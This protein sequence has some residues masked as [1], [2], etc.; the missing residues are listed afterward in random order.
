[1]N[2]TQRRTVDKGN[3]GEAYVILKLIRDFNIVAVKVPQQFFSYDLI[4]SSN[5]RLEVKTAI[6]RNFPRTHAKY[7]TYNSYGWEFQ[8]NPPQLQEDASNYVVG[9]CKKTEN[10]SEDPRCFIIPTSDLREH[11]S[12]F[13]ILA[14]PTRGKRKFWE[15]ENKWESIVNG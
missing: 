6:L 8:R 9:V 11:S 13:K 7:G 14:N 10:F 4:T 2:V 5:K 1:M 3:V 12:V 15:Y